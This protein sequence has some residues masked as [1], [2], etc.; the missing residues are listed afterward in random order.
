MRRPSILSRLFHIGMDGW[1]KLLPVCASV[2]FIALSFAN[3]AGLAS[4]PA[5]NLHS[6]MRAPE[7]VVFAIVSP[8]LIFRPSNLLALFLVSYLGTKIAFS[9]DSFSMQNPAALLTLCLLAILMTLGDRL[10]WFRPRRQGVFGERLRAVL[11]LA[12]SLTCALLVLVT[13]FKVGGFSR[14]FSG[15]VGFILPPQILL[16]ALAGLLILWLM[17]G[18]NL[19][20]PMLLSFLALP[21]LA[22]ALFVTGLP[23][24]VLMT[25][26]IVCLALATTLPAHNKFVQALTARDSRG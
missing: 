18:L 15:H 26:F 25:P 22:A 17:V 1:S 8:F 4:W 21:T 10:P 5:A 23:T 19:S 11:V 9:Q 3:L 2:L 13:M 16:V 6:F 20:S 14:W 12:L 24:P 7:I